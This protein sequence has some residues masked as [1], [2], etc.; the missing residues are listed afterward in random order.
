MTVNANGVPVCVAT[1]FDRQHRQCRRT[2]RR[3]LKLVDFERKLG[4]QEPSIDFCPVRYR[5]INK[6][7]LRLLH[8]RRGIVC[9]AL[10]G[11]S[12]GY[13][14]ILVRLKDNNL[15]IVLDQHLYGTCRCRGGN[16]FLDR[17]DRNRRCFDR[18]GRF[19]NFRKDRRYRCRGYR[20][21]FVQQRRNGLD[22][23]SFDRLFLLLDLRGLLNQFLALNLAVRADSLAAREADQDAGV[24][25]EVGR[26]CP[27]AD[28]EGQV[29]GDKI[30][31][32]GHPFARALRAQEFFSEGPHFGDD[33]QP[34]SRKKFDA[35]A[36]AG[37]ILK[38]ADRCA[39]GRIV[40]LVEHA[41]PAMQ[42]EFFGFQADDAAAE[43]IGQAIYVRIHRDRPPELRIEREFQQR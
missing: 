3:Q 16:D 8:D 2:F 18:F 29:R 26:T 22:V 21:G 43:K 4:H 37:D 1:Q 34:L 39:G 5:R 9:R 15:C 28:G 17:H 12:L 36:V 42:A 20:R 33:A 27:V 25:A 7:P 23:E 32:A 24:R 13:F 14:D 19:Q 35:A 38:R 40:L 6:G 10:F 41:G 11:I 31:D 30:L